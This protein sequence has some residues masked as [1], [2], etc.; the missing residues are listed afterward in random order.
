MR[1]DAVLQIAAGVAVL[2]G[3]WWLVDVIG[4]V[5]E[6]KVHARYAAAAEATNLDLQAFNTEDE[7]VSAVA[8]ALRAKAVA[9]ALKVK[10]DKCHATKAQVEALNRIR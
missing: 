5:R 4:D 8:E 3:L 6:A 2:A 9:E 7:R 10:G 1:L